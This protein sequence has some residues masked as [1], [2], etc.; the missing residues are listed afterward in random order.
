MHTSRQT[1]V[2]AGILAALAS[3]AVLPACRVGRALN[4]DPMAPKKFEGDQKQVWK[5]PG[6]DFAQFRSVYVEPV[7]MDADATQ[8]QDVG[9]AD[10]KGLPG[11]FRGDL[12]NAL[13]VGRTV[14]KVPAAGTLV[15]NVQ[16]IRAV[17]NIPQRNIAPQS[18]IGG[19]GYGYAAVR[20]TLKDGGTGKELMT[21]SETRATSRFSLEKMSE[22]GS[23]EKSFEVWSQEVAGLAK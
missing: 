3:L 11:K 2:R 13:G 9:T 17:P 4:D 16:I 22:W 20:V 5:A 21:M 14:V 12:E 15:V 19:T 23:V 8:G 18:Q 6:A 7:A 10:V 1:F